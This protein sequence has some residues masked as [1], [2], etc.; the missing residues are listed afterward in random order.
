MSPP[1]RRWIPNSFST[2]ARKAESFSIS[3]LQCFWTPFFQ[4]KLYRL[5]TDSILVPSTKRF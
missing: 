5:E 1:W 3:L 2:Y 4:T